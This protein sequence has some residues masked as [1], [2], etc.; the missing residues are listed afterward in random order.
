MITSERKID[1]AGFSEDFPDH[2]IFREVEEIIASSERRGSAIEGRN[3]EKPR[4]E[5]GAP[6][7][8][9]CPLHFFGPDWGIYIREDCVIDMMFD[10]A[11]YINWSAVPPI[12]AIGL[13]NCAFYHLYFHE[14]FHHKVESFGL[15]VLATQ[16]KDSYV[17][18]KQNVYKANY[19]TS[20][21]LEESLA[22]AESYKRF[23]E[24]RYFQKFP[25]PFL[26][27]SMNYVKDSIKASPAGYRE[28]I[29]YLDQNYFQRGVNKLQSQLLEG[30]FHQLL[31]SLILGK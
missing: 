26:N 2:E 11:H 16:L 22:S 24:K 5:W 18:Y 3:K 8:W 12:S 30:V 23:F 19:G 17:A 28:G 20:A 13:R 21:C 10:I 4:P 14:Q 15:R 9:Y 29:N 1:K 27:R 25:R 6:C 31:Q 7:A